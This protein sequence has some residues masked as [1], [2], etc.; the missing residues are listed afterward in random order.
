MT[1]QGDA[2]DPRGVIREAYAIEGIGPEDCRSI[3]LDW[4]LTVPAEADTEA[5]I[6]T[7]LARHG[8][9]DHPMTAVLREGLGTVRPRRRGGAVGRRGGSV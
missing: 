8:T 1:G 4:A 6:R 2:A 7:L 3:F 5:L 9:P